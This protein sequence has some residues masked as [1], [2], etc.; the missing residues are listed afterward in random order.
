MK[1]YYSS[2]NP[3]Q[4]ALEAIT[5]KFPPAELDLDGIR[6]ASEL[7]DARSESLSDWC[8]QNARPHWATGDSILEAAELIVLRAQENANI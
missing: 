8:T 3:L 2:E 1:S 6:H 7:D 4:E 5:G